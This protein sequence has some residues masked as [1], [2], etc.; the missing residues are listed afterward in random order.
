[1][2]IFW[3]EKTIWQPFK[4][5][6]MQVIKIGWK[7]SNENEN[8]GRLKGSKV[9]RWKHPFANECLQRFLKP[10]QGL[11]INVATE[12]KKPGQKGQRPVFGIMILPLGVNLAPGVNFYP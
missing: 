3:S 9:D 2:G 12:E 8:E 4:S 1:L 7:F 6:K 10:L 11:L 5:K